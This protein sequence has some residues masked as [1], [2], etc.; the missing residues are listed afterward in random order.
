MGVLANPT[1]ISSFGFFKVMS[2][3]QE[4]ATYNII[5][6]GAVQGGE[7]QYSAVQ[8]SAVQYSAVHI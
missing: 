2:R 1:N 3:S 7:M 5:I 8:C 4:L 6:M